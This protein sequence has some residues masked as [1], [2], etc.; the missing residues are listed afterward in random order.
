[1]NQLMNI[2]LNKL[3]KTYIMMKRRYL[4]S[5]TAIIAVLF[6]LLN[7]FASRVEQKSFFINKNKHIE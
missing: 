5:A 2:F 1:M 4:K 6:C 3:Q 7:V